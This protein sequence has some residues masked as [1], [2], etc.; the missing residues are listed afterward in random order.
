MVLTSVTVTG[1]VAGAAGVPLGVA[2]HHHVVSAMGRSAGTEIP[3]AGIDVYGPGVP[4]PLAL[5]GV[6][7]EVAGAQLPATR[8]ARTGTARAPRTEWDRTARPPPGDSLRGV[9]PGR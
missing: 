8:A 3:G 2:L 7:I 1:L 6:L 9:T 4:A 5:G